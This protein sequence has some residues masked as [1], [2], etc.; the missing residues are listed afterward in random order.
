MEHY[1]AE[2]SEAQFSHGICPDCMRQYYPKVAEK[3]L[4]KK[5]EELDGKKSETVKKD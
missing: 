1:I 5:S 4:K 2:R 3:V